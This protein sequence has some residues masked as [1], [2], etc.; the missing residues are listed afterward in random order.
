[1]EDSAAGDALDT[2]NGQRPLRPAP[3]GHMPY[4]TTRTRAL[5]SFA[6]AATWVI[7]SVWIG[8]AWLHDVA[9][10]IGMPLAI[11]VL[12]GIAWLPGYLN[13]QLLV[14][15]L[16]DRPPD[17]PQLDDLPD[18]TVLVA[19]WNEED[20]IERCVRSILA[21]QWPGGQLRVVV[22][23]DGSTDATREIVEQVA[24]E[25][26]RV[27]L[28]AADHGGKAAALN[29]GLASTS[30]WII[31][32][33]DADTVLHPQA[34]RRA[35]TRMLITP[36][37]VAVAGSLLVDNDDRLLT[38]MQSYDYM[39]SIASV[40]REQALLHST[41][42]AQGA[43]SVYM[44][45]AVAAA[46]GWTDSIG[47]DI[48]LTWGMLERGAWTSFESTA[49]AWTHVPGT[50]RGLARQRKRWARG[51]FEG[52]RAHGAEL[53]R[54]R[55]LVTHSILGN[56][57]FPL[58]DLAFTFAFIPGIILALSGNFM[59]VGPLTL[60]VLPLSMSIVLVMRLRQRRALAQ[61]D[62]HPPTHAGGFALW[63]LTYQLLLAPVSVAGYVEELLS[64]R[65]RW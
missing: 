24:A 56:A 53:L 9:A 33:V 42:V 47:E 46:G 8:Q 3:P 51:M 52:L 10:V 7:L 57:A 49:V 55:R 61:V 21:S 30:D 27:E 18:C 12:T 23:D 34:L 1:M 22:I 65:R 28:I 48:V 26:E 44:G 39:F 60:A 6:V 31:A 17:L 63:F 13:M 37:C 29:T 36:K 25:D 11:M 35:A 14:A 58:V 64:L 54:S 38:R 20:S 62:V 41:L 16:F 43:F 40:K 50:L 15:L 5:V 19:A 59:L 45:S 4:L 32:T 2:A